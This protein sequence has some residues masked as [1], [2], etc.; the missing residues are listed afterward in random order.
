MRKSAFLIAGIA[1]GVFLAKQ[2]ESN[3]ETKKVFDNATDKVKEFASAVATGYK[4]Q[5]A[6]AATPVK[7]AATVSAKRSSSTTKRAR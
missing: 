3:P 1:L 6:K 5:E 7:K 4:E 2:I